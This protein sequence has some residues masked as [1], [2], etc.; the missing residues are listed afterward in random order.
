M[1]GYSQSKPY[2]SFVQFL[3]RRKIGLPGHVASLIFNVF[4]E[5]R[6]PMSF[7]QI[8]QDVIRCRG[9]LP[10]K[11]YE[12][13][14]DWRYTMVKNGL[15]ICMATYD[16]LKEEGANPKASMFKIGAAAMTYIEKA[17]DEKSSV[18][19]CLDQKADVSR[20]DALEQKINK[21]TEYVLFKNPPN[22]E[23]RRLIVQ[24]CQNDFEMMEK[25]LNEDLDEEKKDVKKSLRIVSG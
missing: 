16:E 24:N 8:K 6:T 15:L 11:E 20:V 14:S 1:A 22:N 2:N 13:Y 9:I 19:Q 4:L 12:N 3:K 25:M 10:S 23:K 21:L 18:R 17:L 7:H 5:T